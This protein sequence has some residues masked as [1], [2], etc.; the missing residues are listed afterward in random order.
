MLGEATNDDAG[1]NTAEDFAAFF[2]DKVESV[3]A[4]TMTYHTT[5]R[6]P[7]KA[8]TDARTLDACHHRRSGEAYRVSTV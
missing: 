2:R 5:T 6:R 4:S 3:R 7:S 8:D 1:V